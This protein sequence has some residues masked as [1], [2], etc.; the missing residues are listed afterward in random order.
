MNNEPHETIGRPITRARI[1]P[2]I[3][4]DCSDWCNDD[5]AVQWTHGRVITKS[6]TRPAI[7]VDCSEWGRESSA[8]LELAVTIDPAVDAAEIGIGLFR[9]MESASRLEQA[10]GGA[11]LTQSAV[12]RENGTV[13]LVMAPEQRMGAS[14]RLQE[15][16]AG[17]SLPRRVQARLVG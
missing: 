10:L 8:V 2:A 16:C 4:I 9:L 12:R 17:L 1:R 15:V 5:P 6:H 13:Y 7:E 3:E 11:G 14:S